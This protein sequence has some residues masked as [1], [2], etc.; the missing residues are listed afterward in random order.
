MYGLVALLLLATA[1]VVFSRQREHLSV[2]PP[3]IVAG[4]SEEESMRTFAMASSQMKTAF[5][6]FA[7][8]PA[9]GSMA[10]PTWAN[11]PQK[12]AAY[13]VRRNVSLFMTEKYIPATSPITETDISSFVQ[14]QISVL[15]GSN[16]PP[17]PVLVVN[18]EN[19]AM[20]SLLK[21][22]FIDQ[23]PATGQTATPTGPGTGTEE[24]PP[25][26]VSPESLPSTPGDFGQ[27]IEI[28]R[29]NYIQ[30]RTTGQS[31]YKQAYEAAELWLNRYLTSV[32]SQLR[33]SNGDLKQFVDSY[34]NA[35]PDMVALQGKMK[36]I[37]T[38]GP[39]IQDEY[40]TVKR[41]MSDEASRDPS[42]KWN[43]Y[44]KGAIV[45]GI[46]G[47]AAILAAK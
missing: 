26:I 5:T 29:S 15:R 17:P 12:K 20:T 34:S 9:S 41:V 4:D 10:F 19:G 25:P 1:L 31:T 7:E 46:L 2:S 14:S 22:Y 45:A 37:A 6:S 13:L 18:Y 30:Y 40:E 43:Y 24:T 11:T 21:A 3:T 47:I 16:P 23:V 39:E 33:R 42:Q 44:V 32:D 8:S 28:F 35:N 38:E 36:S 27:A